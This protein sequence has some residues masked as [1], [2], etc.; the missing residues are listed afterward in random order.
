MSFYDISRSIYYE[1]QTISFNT[2]LSNLSN[3]SNLPSK[4]IKDDSIFPKASYNDKIEDNEIKYLFK[5]EFK[6]EK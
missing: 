3:L 4:I 5:N 2:N 1:H 6:K